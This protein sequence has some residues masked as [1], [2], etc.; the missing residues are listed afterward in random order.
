MNAG[1][2][3]RLVGLKRIICLGVMAAGVLMV[4]CVPRLFFLGSLLVI[5]GL[6]SGYFVRKPLSQKPPSL[7][8]RKRAA[9]QL[10]A[11]AV[12]AIGVAVSF[13]FPENSKAGFW[14][15]AVVI[16]IGIGIVVWLVVR[17]GKS[18]ESH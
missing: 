13:Q 12:L 16:W 10:G 3:L 1:E 15:S 6:V 17:R 4:G 9:L 7:P 5:I 11:L 8:F 2:L 14:S 18:R